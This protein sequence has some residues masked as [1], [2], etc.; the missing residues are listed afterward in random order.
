MT[1]STVFSADGGGI[2]TFFIT[3]ITLPG[4]WFLG[5][6]IE[7]GCRNWLIYGF[8]Q[9]MILKPLGSETKG[10]FQNPWEKMPNSW[11]L[12]LHKQLVWKRLQW[13]SLWMLVWGQ[14]LSQMK[15]GMGWLRGRP[16]D[17][18][19]GSWSRSDASAGIHSF[20]FDH[21]VVQ[22][23]RCS[24]PEHDL[25]YSFDC[26]R[27]ER[28]EHHSRYFGNEWRFLCIGRKPVWKLGLGF[29][30]LRTM[31]FPLFPQKPR[32]TT[33]CWSSSRWCA[34]STCQTK[35]QLH[36]TCTSTTGKPRQDLDEVAAYLLHPV[37]QT[38]QLSCLPS[39]TSLPEQPKSQGLVPAKPCPLSSCARWSSSCWLESLIQVRGRRLEDYYL[40]RDL[41]CVDFCFGRWILRNDAANRCLHLAAEC[42]KQKHVWRARDALSWLQSRVCGCTNEDPFLLNMEQQ[43]G[44]PIGSCRMSLDQGGLIKFLAGPTMWGGSGSQSRSLSCLW[45]RPS[46]AANS[47]TVWWRRSWHLPLQKRGK[48]LCLLKAWN[49][50]E[51]LACRTSFWHRYSRRRRCPPLAEWVVQQVPTS[52]RAILWVLQVVTRAQSISQAWESTTGV[53]SAE[54]TS[55]TTSE[56]LR[57]LAKELGIPAADST[58]MNRQELAAAVEQKLVEADLLSEMPQDPA[59]PEQEKELAKNAASLDRMEA[60]ILKASRKWL[61]RWWHTF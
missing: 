37:Q 4:L 19:S 33:Q 31:R 53:G 61:R 39:S 13:M 46:N 57:S 20:G 36:N 21:L 10:G 27:V 16:L 49:T 24:L 51:H 17:A 45:K 43:R 7:G 25:Q 58:A 41:L 11:K 35:R 50:F 18:F 56:G 48:A 44:R 3:T 1:G 59:V 32:K 54:M 40:G 26:W 2:R 23:L 30:Y 47:K 15:P 12:I 28:L 22:Q 34:R 5:I 9:L 29:Q 6:P 8:I 55:E 52:C 14:P 38:R 60:L 42:N